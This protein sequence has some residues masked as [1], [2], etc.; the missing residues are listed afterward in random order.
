MAEVRVLPVE[1]NVALKGKVY[2]A[3][4]E[5][6]TT[7]DIYST[8]E[9]PKLDERRRTRLPSASTISS[10]GISSRNRLGGLYCVVPWSIRLHACERCSRSIA[11]VIPT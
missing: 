11:R 8:P 6:I 9:A 2:S 10:S 4:E 7:M 5:A 3:L 1:A